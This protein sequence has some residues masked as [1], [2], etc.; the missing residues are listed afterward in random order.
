MNTVA[1]LY[2]FMLYALL[3]HPDILARVTA[4][5][6][7]VA[8][9]GRLSFD[10]IRELTSTQGLVLE[11]LRVY[12]P[13]P[14]SSCTARRT[15]EFHGFRVDQGTRVMVA[16]TVPHHLPEHFE[17]PEVF[18]IGRGFREKRRDDVYAPFSVGSHTCLGAGMSEVLAVATVGILVSR[19]RLRLRSP[20]YRL[21]IQST[22]GPNP[23]K[24]FRVTVV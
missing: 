8:P 20:D 1:Y 11:T 4:E 3:R 13:A 18:D 12:P 24:G 19:V 22:P 15:F 10:S 9:D 23:S 2:S 14:L 16:T 6:G 7:R 17:N 5:V 21:A